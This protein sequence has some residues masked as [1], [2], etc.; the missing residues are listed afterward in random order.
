MESETMSLK[1][2]KG[3]DKL[4]IILYGQDILRQKAEPVNPSDKSL[5]ILT[6]KMIDVAIE[7]NGVGLAAPQIGESKRII[8]ILATGKKEEALVMLNP[9]LLKK[10]KEQVLGEER[11]LSLP[12]L[13]GNVKRPHEITVQWTD[14]DGET[15]EA[16]F[17]DFEAT[18]IQH[19]IDHLEGI[20]F[21][22]KATILSRDKIKSTMKKYQFYVDVN[23]LLKGKGKNVTKKRKKKKR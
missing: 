15:Q 7:K 8:V 6:D 23:K 2:A 3:V 9:E 20:L 13:R 18:V 19:E 12:L 10:S 22:D 4:E 11:C 17:E 1:D 21:I 5:R 16:E 14:L